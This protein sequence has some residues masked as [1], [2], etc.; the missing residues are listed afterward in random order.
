MSSR[1][2]IKAT[3]SEIDGL[4]IGIKVRFSATT[5]FKDLE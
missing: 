4:K 3:I 1:V 2:N 5:S